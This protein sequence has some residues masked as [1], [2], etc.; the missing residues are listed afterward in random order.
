ME[1][2]IKSL[3]EAI[4]NRRAITYTYDPPEPG[5]AKGSR[6]GQ[7]HAVFQASNGNML[8][9]IYKTGGVQTDPSII[10]PDWQTYKVRYL[11]IVD[12]MGKQFSLAPNYNPHSR[13]YRQAICKA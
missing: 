4:H 3:C 13:M 10:L 9:H 11:Q 1:S 6:F 12:G 5:Y 8:V 7:P 2:I